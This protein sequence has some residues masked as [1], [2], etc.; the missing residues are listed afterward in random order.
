MSFDET[1]GLTALLPLPPLL[2]LSSLCHLPF[3]RHLS[4]SISLIP[5]NVGITPQ[6]IFSF[7]FFVLRP[8]LPSAFSPS[9]PS[10]PPFP[11]NVHV[12]TFDRCHVPSY[13]YT[14]RFDIAGAPPD[15]RS[16]T[17]DDEAAAESANAPASSS[18]ATNALFGAKSQLGASAT[19]NFLKSVVA[20]HGCFP[21]L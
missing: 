3:P 20:S 8:L 9:S 4:L 15:K 16:K 1:T 7:S 5:R 17:E 19:N 6:S 12:P 21:L 14:T 10:S 2:P 13:L 11:D 18:T